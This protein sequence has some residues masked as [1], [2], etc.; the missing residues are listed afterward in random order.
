MQE[1]AVALL[2]PHPS[3]SN[4][5]DANTTDKLRRHIECTGNYEPLAVR[6]HLA[7]APF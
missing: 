4:Y 2:V 7:R 3:N 6:T 5:M 1:I